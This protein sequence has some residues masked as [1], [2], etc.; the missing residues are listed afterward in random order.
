MIR[1]PLVDSISLPAICAILRWFDH[2]LLVALHPEIHPEGLA[3]DARELAELLAAAE[4]LP[5]DAGARG[6]QL[7]EAARGAAL[8]QL[9]PDRP[10]VELLVHTRA[11][12][13]FLQ[14]MQRA[15]QRDGQLDGEADC[16]YHLSKLFP[17]LGSRGEWAVVQHYVACADEARPLVLA[18]Q[19]RLQLYEGYAAV[20]TQSYERGA[21][22][23]TA[24]LQQPDLD[25]MVQ[26]HALNA[27]GQAHHFQTEYDQALTRYREMHS[28]AMAAG[29]RTY[30][31]VALINMSHEYNDLNYFDR[32]LELS[33]QSLAIFRELGDAYHEADALSAVGNNATRLGLWHV[34]QR[35]FHEAIELY[36]ALGL[37]GRL[38]STYCCQ[39]I[40]HHMLGDEQTSVQAYRQALAIAESVDHADPA[41]ALDTYAHSGFLYQTQQRW[42]EAEA[43]YSAAERLAAQVGNKLWPSLLA[44]QRGNILKRQGRIAET[45]AAYR[46][47]IERIEA[48][49]TTTESEDI[50]LGLLGTT[51]QVYE[52]MVLLCVAEGRTED[53]FNYVERARSRAFLDALIHKAPELYE[54]L[55]R[56]VATLAEVQRRLPA[57]AL[58]IEYFTTGVVP[59]GEHLL[60][61]LPPENRR[62]REHLT[63]PPQVLIFAITHDAAEVRHAALDPSTL[64]PMPGDPGPGRRLL[65]GRRLPLLYERLIGPVQHLLRGRSL[66]YLAP[67]GPLHYVPFNALHTENGEHLL[68]ADG[69]MIAYAPSATILL[70][71]CL[72]RPSGRADNFLALGYNDC[73]EIGL[74]HAEAEARSIAR[75]MGGEAWTGPEAKSAQLIAAAQHVRW[76]HFAGHAIYKPRDPLDSELRLGADDSLSARTIMGE[77]TL[78][79]DLVTLS[80]CTSG[81]SQVVPGDELLGLQRAFLYAGAPAIVCTL[82][83]AADIVARLVMERFYTQ[84]RQGAPAAAALR[85]AQI[86]VREMTGRD[87]L[88]TILRWRREHPED[89]AVLKDAAAL[90]LKQLDDKPFASPFCWAPFMLIGRPY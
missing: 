89:E 24:L 73:G 35:H 7:S 15:E 19:Q 13:Y 30:E 14:C 59:R 22:I 57:D 66:L 74:D 54:T 81:L 65:Y 16:F 90:Y 82:W 12:H 25:A 26:I 48:L 39:G 71:N 2:K 10:H 61:K 50:K 33:Q 9:G 11:F 40:L 20:R 41:T 75:L 83:E 58:L 49:R 87:A 3:P 34:A 1:E 84:L 67:H 70:R 72:G 36:K 88:A 77:L 56:P 86:A 18:H 44:Y 43:A 23:L 53:A 69:P 78:R 68:A 21:T 52:A 27:L 63:E 64:R 6:Y 8:A 17:L 46:Q 42:D 60:N 29:E 79:A 5:A 85:D 51:Q 28:V 47:A 32:A 31:G 4:A 55:D 37:T 45:L 38:A 76:L 80:A 62:L